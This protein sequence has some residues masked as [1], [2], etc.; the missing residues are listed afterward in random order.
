M[1]HQMDV[2][3]AHHYRG[4]D[5][6]VKFDWQKPNDEAPIAAHVVAKGQVEGLGKV[7][8]ELNGPWE[9]YQQAIAD[10][11]KAAEDWIDQQMP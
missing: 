6:F 3:L 9:D 8:V 10:A 4:R 1:S 5:V 2:P 11:V 7:A